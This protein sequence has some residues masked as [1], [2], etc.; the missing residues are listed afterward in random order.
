MSTLRDLITNTSFFDDHTCVDVHCRCGKTRW[1]ETVIFE[2][3]VDDIIGGDRPFEFDSPRGI[4]L[5]GLL[6]HPRTGEVHSFVSQGDLERTKQRWAEI[7]RQIAE[8]KLTEDDTEWKVSYAP[9]R[10]LAPLPEDDGKRP[11][12]TVYHNATETNRRRH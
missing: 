9:R 8:E 12:I 3:N 10:R 6:R 7:A 11:R 1:M 4:H 2:R 5:Y